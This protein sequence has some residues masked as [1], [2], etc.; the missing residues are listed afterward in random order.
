MD[1]SFFG[2]DTVE[3]VKKYAACITKAAQTEAVKVTQQGIISPAPKKNVTP[4][5]TQA[6]LP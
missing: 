6:A 4:P 1:F 2:K 3:E 5:T